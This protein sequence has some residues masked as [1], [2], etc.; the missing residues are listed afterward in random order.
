MEVNFSYR[1]KVLILGAGASKEYGLPIW[2]ELHSLIK[3]KLKNGG[4]NQYPRAKD[5]LA[6]LDKV[7]EKNEYKTIDEC[8][9]KESVA[10]IYHSDG[11]SVENDLFSLVKDI[12]NEV[13]GENNEGWITKFNDKVLRHPSSKLEEEIAFINYNYDNVLEKNLLKFG[14]LPGKHLRLNNKPRLDELS[15][16]IVPVLYAHGNLYLKS[17]IPKDSHTERYY[18]TMKSGVAGY[19]DVV[20]CYESYHHTV[21]HDLYADV[22]ELYILGLG[23]GLKYNL[24]KLNL[25]KK[26][27]KIFV[28]ISDANNDEEIIK[29]LTVKFKVPADKISIHRTCVSLVAACF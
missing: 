6:W 8:I 19:I 10:G 25:P 12:F 28:T 17:E 1:N 9:E 29:F 21:E 22:L 23:G 7:G 2:E 20:S 24:G 11:D 5:V 14:H 4:E 15:T 13:Y 16:A 3:N 18:Q 27:S 26:V